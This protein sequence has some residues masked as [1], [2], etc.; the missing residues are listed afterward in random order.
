MSTFQIKIFND[1]LILSRIEL[2]DPKIAGIPPQ[3]VQSIFMKKDEIIILME[4]L[5]EHANKNGN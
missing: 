4:A 1:E 2:R 3:E 5:K